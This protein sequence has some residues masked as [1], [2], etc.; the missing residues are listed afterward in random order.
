MCFGVI[1]DRVAACSDFLRKRRAQAYVLADQ[2]KRGF[3]IVAVEQ[4]E[5]F[6]RD[7]RIWPVVERYGYRGWFIHAADRRAKEL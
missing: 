7:G 4:I 1:A 5:E 3:R 2:E 6:W